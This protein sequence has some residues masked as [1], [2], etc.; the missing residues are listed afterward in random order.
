MCWN[1][2]ASTALA[3]IGLSS[4]VYAAYKG[5]TPAV[6]ITLGYFSLMEALQAY[7]Y[8][9]IDNCMLPANQIA[10]LLGYLHIAYQPFFANLISMHFIPTEARQKVQYLVYSACFI[11]SIFM[12]LQLYPFDWAGN[13]AIGRPL[14]SDFPTP[15]SVHGNWHI[16]W[17]V[18]VN[19]IGNW[20]FYDDV[21]VFNN[22]YIT[23]TFAVF[24]MPLLY[25]SW[26]FTLYH[27]SIGP[28]LASLTTNNINE[29]PAIWCL[30]SI[31]LLLIVVKTP[32]RK[33]LY[34]KRHVL[35]SV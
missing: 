17:L 31:G 4:T 11:S 10:T 9:V 3:I 32:I 19:G 35:T 12:I 18:P 25:G 30:F 29:W 28:F 14:C 13:C 15:C 24:V 34:V 23:Y 22:G 21:P 7:T 5:D 26:R 27:W 33:L 1:G 2:E 16:A 20:L 8:L 6:W